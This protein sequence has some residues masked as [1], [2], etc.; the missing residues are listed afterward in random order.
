MDVTYLVHSGFLVETKKAYYLF[1]YIKGELP[2][3]DANKA[4]Y[5]FASHSHADHFSMK[6]FDEEISKFA[7]AYILGYDIKRKFRKSQPDTITQN[8]DKIYWVNTDTTIE[9][10]DCTVT[11]LKSTDIGVA[12]AISEPDENKNINIYHAGDLNWW[13]R[14]TADNAKNRNIEVN[15]K[16]SIDKIKEVHFDVAFLPLDPTLKAS[17]YYG[18]KYFLDTVTADNVFPMHFWEDYNIIDR[19][20]LEYGNAERIKKI[21]KEGQ[22]FTI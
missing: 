7:T 9:L 16:R 22:H 10:A 19:Y 17:Y 8:A 12:F 11:N 4:L 1:D 21:E 5:V 6:I 2:L 20:I 14:E 18:F 3:F 13:H 15:F